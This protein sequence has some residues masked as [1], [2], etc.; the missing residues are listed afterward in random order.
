MINR[1]TIIQYFKN[2]QDNITRELTVIDGKAGFSSDEWI[3]QEGGGGDT[4][5][6]VD[7]AVFEKGGVN[8]SHVFGKMPAVLKSETRKGDFFH[9]T[10][11]S[12][13]IHSNHPFVP[14]IHMNV[15]YF[16]MRDEAD[17]NVTD[18]WFGGGIDL[19]PAYPN[20]EDTTFFHSQLKKV[21]DNHDVSYYAEFKKECDA[22]FTIVHREQMRGV[23]G[24]FFDHLRADENKSLE[25]IFDFVKEVGNAFV[26][27]Y[28]EIVRRNRDKA[29]NEL[30]KNWQWIRRGYYAEFNLVYDRGTHFG[31][32][33]NGR[34]ESILMSLPPKAMW[35]YDFQPIEGSEEAETLNYFQPQDWT[36]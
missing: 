35:K 3:R 1:D 21:C 2:L 7:G 15:R 31:L 22:Y 16:E 10:G 13:V 29:Y 27:V 30:H 23:G 9:A 34:I 14:I 20:K 24:I 36:N 17:G 32:K 19:S 4:R 33:S 12:I 25:K 26:P 6:M 28:S 5:V 8:F 18:S 11:V